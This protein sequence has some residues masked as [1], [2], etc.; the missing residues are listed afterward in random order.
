MTKIT[1]QTI[2]GKLACKNQ[3][4]AFRALFGES[5]DITPELCVTHAFAFDWD[6]AG[7]NLLSPTAL[8]EYDRTSASARAE[9]QRAGASAR[10]TALAGY[11]RAAAAAA[12]AEYNRARA[13]AW[14]EYNR[15]RAT[16]WANAYINDTL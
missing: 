5:V 12:W 4:D 1:Y 10:A 8:A 3:L 9:H 11:N 16:A 2:A 7:D 14:A 15:A 6:W 13:T